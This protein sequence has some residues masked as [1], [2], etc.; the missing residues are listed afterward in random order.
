MADEIMSEERIN[1]TIEAIANDLPSIVGFISGELSTIAA[2]NNGEIDVNNKKFRVAV[3]SLIHADPNNPKNAGKAV[4]SFTATEQGINK[5]IDKLIAKGVPEGR[6]A[7]LR[8]DM[9]KLRA[10]LVEKTSSSEGL[11]ELVSDRVKSQLV[12]QN[13]GLWTKTPEGETRAMLPEQKKDLARKIEGN[14]VLSPDAIKAVLLDTGGAKAKVAAVVFNQINE[15]FS[16]EGKENSGNFYT[17]DP[18]KL[19]AE[20]VNIAGGAISAKIE[21]DIMPAINVINQTMET[22]KSDYGVSASPEMAA[23]MFAKLEP[24]LKEFGADYLRD[25]EDMLASEIAKSVDT[26]KT[27]W[28]QIKFGFSRLVPGW[29]PE[30]S[31][32]TA[33]SMD[34]IVENLSSNHITATI[35]ESARVNISEPAHQMGAPEQTQDLTPRPAAVTPNLPHPPEGPPPS[36]PRPPEG[37]PPSRPHPPEGSPPIPPRPPKELIEQAKKMKPHPPKGARPP[38]KPH[39]PKEPRPSQGR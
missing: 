2:S 9:Q 18:N 17:V 13:I 28:S 8:N 14:L 6:F 19:T 33:T 7:K 25:N 24:K 34:E 27:T 35:V 36:R 29:K 32:S 26:K 1:K 37:P 10:E 23:E 12:L 5:K 15:E 31:L 38:A 3:E 21:N 30:V 16:V 20:S 4:L 39:P 11:S 22:L